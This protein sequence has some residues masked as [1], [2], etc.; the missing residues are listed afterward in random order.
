MATP[1]ARFA[2]ALILVI[3]W[4]AITIVVPE[5]QAQGRTTLQE[6]VTRDLA[7]G[8]AGSAAFLVAAAWLA[9]WHDLGLKAPGPRGWWKLLW[10]PALY[11]AV[12]GGL[13]ITTGKFAA[14]VAVM[15][16]ANMAMVGFSEEL[17]F[18]GVLWGAARRALPFWAGFVLVSAAF[19]L[20]HVLNALL[21][22][23][24]AA[25]GVQAT[26]AFMSGSAFLALRIRTRSLLP[27]M[28]VHGLWD[29]TVFLV[30]SGAAPGPA[31]PAAAWQEQLT[32]GLM[33]TGPLF[34]Y[35][36]WLVRSE[37]SRAGWRDDG[38]MD[39]AHPAGEP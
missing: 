13:G 2:I 23:E 3:I 22:G 11:L 9:G 17:A 8:V 35:G 28:A 12:L 24:L 38:I 6:L 21:T 15:M 1:R 39:P 4:A 33:L 19:G 14:A 5:W 27:V 16:L 20:V 37:A 34:L 18:R 29:F 10:L 7:W 30:G 26:N 25:A 32:Y 36:L 31:A